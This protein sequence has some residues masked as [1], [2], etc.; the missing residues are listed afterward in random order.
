MIGVNSFSYICWRHR[1][2]WKVGRPANGVFFFFF[3]LLSSVN[4]HLKGVL[5]SCSQLSSAH[6]RLSLH[7]L[8]NSLRY[9]SVRYSSSLY[10]SQHLMSYSSHVSPLLVQKIVMN[11]QTGAPLIRHLRTS[12]LFTQACVNW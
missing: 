9:E 4:P 1:P 12:L 8:L 10:C 5:F 7:M 2:L 3:Y 6:R 11:M